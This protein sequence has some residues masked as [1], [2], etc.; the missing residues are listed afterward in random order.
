MRIAS[1]YLEQLWFENEDGKRFI[2]P[3]DG[4]MPPD[5]PEGFIYQHAQF[6]T[7]LKEEVSVTIT[8]ERVAACDHPE[9]MMLKDADIIDSHE[10]RK[11]RKCGGYQQKLKG[12]PWSE[13]WDSGHSSPL[14]AVNRSWMPELVLA[15]TRPTRREMEKQLTRWESSQSVL[16]GAA[17]PRQTAP[18]LFDLEYAIIIA[19][20][21]CERCMNAL[22]WTYGVK[23]TENDE[24]YPELSDKWK[25][26]GTS[27]HF[28]EH[29]GHITQPETDPN[30]MVQPVEA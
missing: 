28:C 23:F 9:D 6:V 12:E 7:Y 29:M 14:G 18:P 26:A 16:V 17:G 21:A 20:T 25:A 11:C 30:R 13:D 3:L 22:G 4:D 10:G 2:P 8:P 15:M 1:E 19:A 27:C 5:I 24:G